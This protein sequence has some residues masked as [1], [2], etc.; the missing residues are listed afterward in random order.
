MPPEPVD[1][2]ETMGVEP[3]QLPRHIAIIMDGNGRW[4]R[5]RGM[6]RI[7]G[8]REGAKA[9]RE[10]VEACVN[11]SVGCLTL[12]SFSME[13]WSRPKDEVAGLMQ[14]YAEYLVKERDELLD[15]K[16]RL[17]QVGRRDNLPASVLDELD[18]TVELCKD[19][20]GLTLCLALNYGS[21]YE[22][23]EATR[24]L[25]KRVAN[26]DLAPDQIDED[27]ISDSLYTA[28]IPDPDLLIRTAGE[29]RLSNFLLWQL[30]YAEFYVTDVYWPDFRTDH[31]Y[32]AIRD[33]AHRERRFGRVPQVSSESTAND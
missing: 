29:Y 15:N 3:D 31:L 16:V 6:M 8:H 17:V 7:E 30:S 33:Y 14:L 5:A 28:G 2:R 25:A 9:V 20:G 19:N 1:P 4:A 27:A 23:V 13:N 24:R 21:R 12:Y 32:A 26:G 18:R 11:L 10:V 22:I